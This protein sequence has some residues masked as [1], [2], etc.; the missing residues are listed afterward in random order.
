MSKLKIR[1]DTDY[2]VTAQQIA[3]LEQGLL[4]LRQSSRASQEAVDAIAAVQYREIISLRAELDAAMGFDE[5]VSDLEIAL[6]GPTIGIGVAPS[7]EISSYLNRLNGATRTL[8]EYLAATAYYDME[9]Q[10]GYA[11]SSSEF[12]LVGVAAG[13]V[14]LKLSLSKPKTLFG[15]MELAPVK[16]GL[17][18]MLAVVNWVG[19]KESPTELRRMVNDDLLMRILLNQVSRLTPL[20]NSSVNRVEFSGQLADPDT[21]YVLSRRTVGRIRDAAAAV[22]AQPQRATETGKLRT[23]DL[24]SGAFT[25]RQRPDDKPPLRCY[26]SREVMTQ[27]I[28]YMV[29]DITV[30]V[31]GFLN[32]DRSGRPSSLSV[33]EV[34]EADITG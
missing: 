23:A 9:G 11:S 14:R 15:D 27:A 6:S 17:R 32:H 30:E 31:V 18:L 33:Q 29:E 10:T 24:D 20:P 16:E 25:L 5:S 19:S 8:A 12:Q 26:I 7:R 22:R 3:K 28:G 34:Y 21:R 4:S 1:T 13:S 2:R